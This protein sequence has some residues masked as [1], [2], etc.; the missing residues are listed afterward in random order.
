MALYGAIRSRKHTGFRKSFNQEEIAKALRSLQNCIRIRSA[1]NL[2]ALLLALADSLPP[3]TKSSNSLK[4]I[5]VHLKLNPL[6]L[7]I[8]LDD[9]VELESANDIVTLRNGL[10][11]LSR[12]TDICV[13]LTTKDLALPEDSGWRH[14][15]VRPLSVETAVATFKAISGHLDDEDEFKKLVLSL[16]CIPFS[17]SIAG[18]LGL[19]IGRAHV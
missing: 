19:K 11:E 18:R 14:F 4:D 3:G 10:G 5:V 15:V 17:I 13:V 7:L 12:S 1:P 9:L 2:D 6:S 8:T 16:G